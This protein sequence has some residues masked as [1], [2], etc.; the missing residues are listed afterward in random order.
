VENGGG[1]LEAALRSADASRSPS[2]SGRRR[3]APWRIQHTHTHELT[4]A[5]LART[6]HPN[7]AVAALLLLLLYPAAAPPSLTFRPRLLLPC[8]DPSTTTNTTRPR[9]EHS[10]LD[11]R[12]LSTFTPYPPTLRLAR[13]LLI[14]YHCTPARASTIAQTLHRSTARLT[15]SRIHLRPAHQ[16]LYRRPLLPAFNLHCPMRSA[17]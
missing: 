8:A 3:E 9:L 13:P 1:S 5:V 7:T 12:S 6:H 10:L 15:Y 2:P 14:R 17:R 11:S 4:A 16:L